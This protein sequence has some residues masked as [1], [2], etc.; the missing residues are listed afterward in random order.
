MITDCGCTLVVKCHNKGSCIQA[1][2]EELSWLHSNFMAKQR[3][4][5]VQYWPESV[6]FSLQVYLQNNDYLINISGRHFKEKA[7]ILAMIMWFTCPH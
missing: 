7:V 1:P 5:N 3:I 4:F 6:L 2:V